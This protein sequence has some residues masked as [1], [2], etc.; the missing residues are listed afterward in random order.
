M[1]PK[2]CLPRFDHDND[3]YW[4]SYLNGTLYRT[5]PR[6]KTTHSV[7][8]VAWV[9]TT[10]ASTY[11][12]PLTPP[13]TPCTTSTPSLPTP[14]PSPKE[15]PQD[16][17]TGMMDYDTAVL[18]LIAALA[19]PDF[20]P[21]NPATSAGYNSLRG[22]Y[23]VILSRLDDTERRIARTVAGLDLP[24]T[25]PALFWSDPNSYARAAV[26]IAS[27]ACLHYGAHRGSQFLD[28]V[29]A[30]TTQRVLANTARL[31]AHLAVADGAFVGWVPPC[32]GVVPSDHL[33]G[34]KEQYRHLPPTAT[35][36]HCGQGWNAG[37][38]R[39]EPRRGVL[40]PLKACLSS[41]K[42]VAQNGS[43]RS[44]SSSSFDAHGKRGGVVLVVQRGVWWGITEPEW[45][46]E[47]KAAVLAPIT[48]PALW[49]AGIWSPTS[50][51]T[52]DLDGTPM[53]HIVDLP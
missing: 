52:G 12:T 4:T 25:I 13:L 19:L 28:A 41:P 3:A 17:I 11:P 48:A 39:F 18:D 32:F 50:T 9:S 20:S 40:P 1:A 51:A 38:L 22:A 26:S 46:V 6:T 44:S 30:E 21:T 7:S 53:S 23:N 35:F 16:L 49:P 27:Y 43:R 15:T 29:L 34:Y 45:E 42:L 2:F 24:G 37:V 33:A 36:W 14:P 10:D 8:P 31:R 5:Y 47:A